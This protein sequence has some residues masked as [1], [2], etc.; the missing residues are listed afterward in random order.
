MIY[1]EHVTNKVKYKVPAVYKGTMIIDGLAKEISTNQDEFTYVISIDDHIFFVIN[2]KEYSKYGVRLS[3]NKDI[4][5]II[6][7]YGKPLI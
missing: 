3:F 4:E 1:W 5:P 7:P 6:R 2:N